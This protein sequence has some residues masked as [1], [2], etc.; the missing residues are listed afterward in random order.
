L[1]EGNSPRLAGE[2]LEH[3]KVL[4][5]VDDPLPPIL[6]HRQTMRIVDGMHRMRAAQLRGEEFIAV[7]FL[8]CDDEQAFVAAVEA[9]TRHGMPLTLADREA[10]AARIIRSR[11]ESSDRSIAS[12]TG[13]SPRTVA[14]VRRRIPQV[15]EPSKRI[16]RDG[17][18]RPLSSAEARRTAGEFIRRNPTASLRDVAKRTGL[19]P[20][21]VLDVRERLYRGEDPVPE[22]LRSDEITPMMPDV[23]DGAAGKSFAA[24]RES[25]DHQL[26]LRKLNRDPSLRFSETG[27]SLL[28][29]LSSKSMNADSLE[30]LT[31]NMPLHCTYTIA[32][33]ARGFANE[34]LAFAD[35]LERLRRDTA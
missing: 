13:L 25:R 19:S 9:N 27:R 31:E 3:V 32:E 30:E 18:V 28:R 17:R 4:A 7:E 23:R 15:G 8:D 34:W 35:N 12:I 16:G 2:S 14:A 33:I 26:L 20:A 21:T 22:R 5:E 1:V 10:A 24:A 11:P 29:W 6:V